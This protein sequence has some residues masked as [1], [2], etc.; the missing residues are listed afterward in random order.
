[1]EKNAIRE[2]AKK[3]IDFYNHYQ[4]HIIGKIKG[5][6][7]SR[8]HMDNVE[9]DKIHKEFLDKLYNCVTIPYIDF[10]VTTKCSL[11]C[12]DCTQ[13]IPYV[14]GENFT[15]EQIRQWLKEMFYTVDYVSFMT[16]LGGEPFVNSQL[17]EI[18]KEV[19]ELQHDGKVGFIRIV[20]NGTV[21]PEQKVID[22]VRDNGILVLISDYSSIFNDRQKHNLINFLTKMKENRCIY[23][24]A[25]DAQWIDL[26]RPEEKKHH[27]SLKQT[28]GT[29]F[30]RDCVT[31][32]EGKLY[33]CPRSYMLSK[34]QKEYPSEDEVIDFARIT[35]KDE[36]VKKIIAFY[37]LTSLSACEYCNIEEKRKKIKAAIQMER[38]KNAK[39]FSVD[40]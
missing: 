30:I 28:F 12:R 15:V 17:Y 36:M 5:E 25:K 2:E 29:C 16:I 14:E 27:D 39:I 13:W 20:T 9:I 40:K 4:G 33:H 10:S 19:L 7:V 26:G 34:M 22:L 37:S 35:S 6:I 38:E 11:K 32:M 8:Y 18:L 23:W 31:F 3:N 1:M 21:L 24:Y